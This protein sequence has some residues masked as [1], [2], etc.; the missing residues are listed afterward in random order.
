[1]NNTRPNSII[2]QHSWNS[3]NYIYESKNPFTKLRGR[4]RS[5]YLSAANPF[6]PGYQHLDLFSRGDFLPTDWISQSYAN[7]GPQTYG[8]KLRSNLHIKYPELLQSGTPLPLFEPM[9]F[10]TDSRTGSSHTLFPLIALKLLILCNIVRLCFEF[11]YQ[12]WLSLRDIS[13]ANAKRYKMPG[14]EPRCS[15]TTSLLFLTKTIPMHTYIRTYIH[16]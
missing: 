6:L 7:C 10:K 2:T 11:E 1:M 5:S 14:K 15:S 12:N 8:Y 4:A 9:H 3:R 13:F 16:T